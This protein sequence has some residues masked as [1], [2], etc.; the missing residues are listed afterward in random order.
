[1][2][3]SNIY[4]YSKYFLIGS[5]F[6]WFIS[7]IFFSIAFTG[8]DEYPML[9]NIIDWSSTFIMDA[10]FLVMIATVINKLDEEMQNDETP[11]LD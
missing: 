10:A 9:K 2:K 5:F 6:T 7:N 4:R 11:K 8:R 1:M 3:R